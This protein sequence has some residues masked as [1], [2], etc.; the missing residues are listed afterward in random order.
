MKRR[1]GLPASLIALFFGALATVASTEVRAA[2]DPAEAATARKL[3]AVR[4]QPLALEAFL[5]E[6]PKGGDLHNHFTGSIY[7]ESYM[8]WAVEDQLCVVVE[9]FTLASG[10]CDAAAGKPPASAVMQN[11][12]LYNQAID[13][14]SMRLWPP[15]TNGHHHFF[16]TF[17]KFGAIPRSRDGDMLAEITSRAAAEHVSYLELMM[18]PD[19]GVATRLGRD[20]ACGS[21]NS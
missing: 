2:G 3:A 11:S 19:G 5:R 13:A 18:T 1:A 10:P 20:S 14:W 9:T 8:R 6:M 4:N 16:Q 21:M 7:A 17:L 12:A 15:N